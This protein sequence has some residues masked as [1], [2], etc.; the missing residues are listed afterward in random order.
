MRSERGSVLVIVALF[1]PVALVV[2]SLAIDV[3]SWFLSKDH[4]QMQA[5]SAALAGADE[6]LQK[7]ATCPGNVAQQASNYA[8]PNGAA[9]PPAIGSNAERGNVAINTVVKC[10]G[11][12]SYVDVSLRNDNPGAFISSL[13]PA[14]H[15][16][17]RVSLLQVS[18]NDG[19]G[20]LPYAIPVSQAVDNGS[21]VTIPVNAS[22]NNASQSL[23]CDGTSTNSSG[24]NGGFHMANLE[25]ASYPGYSALYSS[26]FG[27]AKGC[28]STQVNSNPS[29]ACPAT[30]TSP[31][32]CLWEFTKVD[33]P[34]FDSGLIYRFESQAKN[35][36]TSSCKMPSPNPTCTNP[37]PIPTN[38]WSLY[39][40]SGTVVPNDP[41]V[42]TIY[43]VPNG[44]FTTTSHQIP[45]VGY[46][47]FYMATWDHDPCAGKSDPK[48]PGPGAVAGFFMK[49]V[50][51]SST[52]TGVAPCNPT[53]SA[54]TETCVAQLTQ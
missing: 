37:N 14:I 38:N 12:G 29:A 9:S 10:P 33:E 16:H 48:S 17:A 26:T 47:S 46:A 4:L 19:T 40:S 36:D 41:R 25:S 43:V 35:S 28:Q 6:F 44:S 54:I 20:V 5:D 45:I 15:A 32:N 52:A 34:C 50:Q 7:P 27:G 39:Q 31:P 11:E 8:A 49:L 3:P 22:A 42:I 1:L 51:P 24:A 18:Q 23:L 30:P 53:S 21:L 13:N 2:A